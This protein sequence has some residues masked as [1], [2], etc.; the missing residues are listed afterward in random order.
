MSIEIIW[1]Y[2]E[3]VQSPTLID[4]MSGVVKRVQFSITA[5]DSA[6]PKCVAKLI[7]SRDLPPPNPDDFTPEKDLTCEM[8]LAWTKADLGED[9]CR[10]YEADA[11]AMLNTQIEAPIIKRRAE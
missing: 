1:K 3:E 10:I 7:S 2:E 6:H 11:L 4:G 5:K 8:L 9:A